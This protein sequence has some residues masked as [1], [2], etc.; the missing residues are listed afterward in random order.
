M[1]LYRENV[2]S[3]ETLGYLDRMVTELAS[4]DD[5]VENFGGYCHEILGAVIMLGNLGL[6]ADATETYVYYTTELQRKIDAK[7]V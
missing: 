2:T 1:R 4:Y 3:D 6:V 7:E 5:A